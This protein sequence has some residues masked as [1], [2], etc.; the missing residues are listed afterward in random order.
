[1]QETLVFVSHGGPTQYCLKE[2]SGQKYEGGF[3]VGS[4]AVMDAFFE[5]G[6]PNHN[7]FVV[8]GNLPFPSQSP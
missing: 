5:K 6:H 4:D 8:V 2:F 1:M 3:A 7:G